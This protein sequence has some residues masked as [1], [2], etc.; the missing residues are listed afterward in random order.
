MKN[1]RMLQ[2]KGGT[3]GIPS[4][5]TPYMHPPKSNT[6]RYKSLVRAAMVGNSSKGSG[7][8]QQAE[9]HKTVLACDIR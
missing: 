3:Y 2:G 6:K 1:G 7:A 8:I 5:N 9:M 4:S